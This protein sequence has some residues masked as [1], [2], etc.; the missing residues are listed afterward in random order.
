M[1]KITALSFLLMAVYSLNAQAQTEE[2][3]EVVP[4]EEESLIAGWSGEGQLG[5]TSTSGNSDSESL[6][7]KLG[8]S[9]E[10]DK[11][12]HG[13]SIESLKTTTDNVTSAD[14]FIF[15]EKSEYKFGEKAY[16]FGKVRYEDDKFSG[17]DY[18]TS[19]AFGAGYQVLESASQTL[20]VSAGIGYRKIKDTLTQQTKD[21]GILTADASYG[22]II[23]AYAKFSEVLSVEA[24][25][26]N[27]HSESETA[28]QTKINGN[29][30]SKISYLIKHNS[31]V[32][33]G[34]EKT[35]K[36]L[37]VALVYSF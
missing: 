32:A 22:Y 16:A 12:K 20:D 6:N 4:V 1:H 14:S 8:I 2:T 11:W 26:D 29:L 30:A 3:P 27:T 25:D 18:Q 28:L 35:D 9:K 33:V 24:G 7:A 21:G 15:K 13:A 23:S 5:F 17:Y 37:T 31:D 34:I 19:I 10:R 36:I